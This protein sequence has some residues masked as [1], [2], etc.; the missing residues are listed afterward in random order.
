[1]FSLILLRQQNTT[2]WV[3]YKQ[4]KLIAHSPVGQQVQDQDASWVQKLVP[5]PCVLTWL[6]GEGPHDSSTSQRPCPL[7]PPDWT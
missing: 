4:R 1:M 5:S 2:N 3:G 6:K 7:T